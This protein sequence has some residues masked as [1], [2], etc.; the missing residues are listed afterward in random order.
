MNLTGESKVK[1][2]KGEKRERKRE[3]KERQNSRGWEYSQPTT[4]APL[5]PSA[6]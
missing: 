3:R 1:G 4:I 6:T 5:L 2:Y